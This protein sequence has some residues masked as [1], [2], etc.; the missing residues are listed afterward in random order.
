MDRVWFRKVLT[1]RRGERGAGKSLRE[2]RWLLRSS[3]AGQGVQGCAH[4]AE[5]RTVLRQA[6]G[7][8]AL[9]VR[10]GEDGRL[11]ARAAGCHEGRIQAEPEGGRLA[12]LS[13]VDDEAPA[14]RGVDGAALLHGHP[15][16]AGG[17]GIAGGGEPVFA[18]GGV[19][20]DGEL[21]RG[22]A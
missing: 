1:R 18:G 17:E 2:E 15:G 7:F 3:G 4:L 8:E 5:H 16:R 21:D 20:R 12:A 9:E 11:N 14:G 19:G 6:L 22:A 10:M 13:D